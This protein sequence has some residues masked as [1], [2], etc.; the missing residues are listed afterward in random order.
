[1]NNDQTGMTNS[2]ALLVGHGSFGHW[3]LIG[4]WG[5]LIGHFPG[6]NLRPHD[7]GFEH[8]PPVH[9]PLDLA[10]DAAVAFPGFLADD[11]EA[12]AGGDGGAE[13]DVGGAAEADEAFPAYEFTGVKRC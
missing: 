5:L 9:Q 2:K 7:R 8:D 4:H 12:L 10:L 3:A 6:L 11:V 1:M 13:A